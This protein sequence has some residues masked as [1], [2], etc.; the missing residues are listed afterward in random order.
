MIYETREEQLS[1]ALPFISHGLAEGQKCIYIADDNTAG[2]VLAAMTEQGIDVQAARDS[3]ALVVADKKAAYLKQGYFDP[4]WMIGFLKN[5]VAEAQA[6]GFKAL[7]VTGEMTW[8]L[9]H[10][11]GTE[12]L[13]EYENALNRFLPEHDCLAICQYNR[14][15]FPA[16]IIR[17]IIYTHP[18]VIH[19]GQVC[20]NFYYIPPDEFLA[21]D[22]GDRLVK[23]MLQNL[24]IRQQ[25]LTATEGRYRNLFEHAP[26]SL[27]EIDLAPP[28]DNPGTDGINRQ[29]EYKHPQQ[30]Q[31]TDINKTACA[32]FDVRDRNEFNTCFAEAVETGTGMRAVLDSI[33]SALAAGKT[34]IHAEGS[35][36]GNAG[37]TRHLV[38][39]G[40]RTTDS[41]GQLPRILF[42]VLDMT[43]SRE[44]EKQQAEMIEEQKREI[45]ALAHMH[46]RPSSELTARA[47]GNRPLRE[48][49]PDEFD[50]ALHRYAEMLDRALERRIYKSEDRLSADLK[51]LGSR[52][53]FLRAA[54][55]DLVDLH[56]RALETKPDDMPHVRRRALSAEG[57][58]MLLELMGH[59]AY[60]YR[61]FSLG[62]PEGTKP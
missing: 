3:G 15:R 5:A 36:T 18:L 10:V 40:S 47:Y 20:K 48:G 46:T 34:E 39:C 2:Q 23:R 24:G 12:R 49:C 50:E 22:T 45:E 7:R 52:L 59:L 19:G 62:L 41:G 58:L 17:D 16:E 42:S 30:L 44:L 21:P 26:V 4:D 43:E 31:V 1:A 8:A 32:L 11:P 33:L 35:M 13:I 37:K 25:T 6:A 53:G 57:K 60:Y 56:T 27:F 9:G 61:K 14:C 29:T 54:P 28:A 38:F 55:R 51:K